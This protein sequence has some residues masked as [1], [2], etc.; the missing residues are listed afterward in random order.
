MAEVRVDFTISADENLI[1]LVD[2]IMDAI[3]DV[4][5]GIDTGL[6]EDSGEIEVS[7]EAVDLAGV[8]GWMAIIRRICNENGLGSF[9]VKAKG[10]ADNDY[11]SYTAFEILCDANEIKIRDVDFDGSP[12]DES[13]DDDDRM[14]E[15]E[16]KEDEA[17]EVL[18]KKE[19]KKL[20]EEDIY[21]DDDEYDAA[22]EALEDDIDFEE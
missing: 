22:I 8:C 7:A 5:Y 14:S 18:S 21:F 16:E 13:E 3:A 4:G 2:K 1:T 6:D 17:Y 15:Y 10:V 9:S 19:F 12:S 20:N 11:Y